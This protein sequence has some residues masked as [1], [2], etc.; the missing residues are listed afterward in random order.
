MQI[1]VN[2]DYMYMSTLRR[3]C[4][5]LAGP[6]CLIYTMFLLSAIFPSTSCQYPRPF[7][8]KFNPLNTWRCEYNKL[9]FYFS[10]NC[11]V[12]GAR[13][14]SSNSKTL[15]TTLWSDLHN[16]WQFW[17]I[18]AI[19]KERGN[20]ADG[21]WLMN[22]S[23]RIISW[24]SFLYSIDQLIAFSNAHIPLVRFVVNLL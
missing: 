18:D 24:I 13:I 21:L 2:L 3:P 23:C 14:T 22:C 8:S 7:T 6:N 12:F 1:Q 16:Y 20:T 11:T 17:L 10:N 19:D 15:P 9:V 5:P 4:T